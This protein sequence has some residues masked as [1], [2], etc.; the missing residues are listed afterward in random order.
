M[1]LLDRTRPQE[2]TSQQLAIR[3]TSR[4][5]KAWL[6]ATHRC[7]KAILFVSQTYLKD[8]CWQC[9]R[10]TAVFI[11]LMVRAGHPGTALSNSIVLPSRYSIVFASRPACTAV[12]ES[13]NC[14]AK[15]TWR[16]HSAVATQA[17][18]LLPNLEFPGYALFWHTQ[19]NRHSEQPTLHQQS[20][21]LTHNTDTNSDHSM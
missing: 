19:W 20:H 13:S 16:K 5:Q 10:F 17:R 21:Q 11:S 6:E 3:R 4:G 18:K 1:P 14:F 7:I 15:S 9:R 8:C 12:M 2:L